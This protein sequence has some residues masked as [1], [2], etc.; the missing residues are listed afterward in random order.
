MKEL[1]LLA[2]EGFLLLTLVGV[3]VGELGYRGEKF[4][5]TW[6]TA[7]LGLLAALVQVV[8]LSRFGSS[9]AFSGSFRLD[10][11]A[12]ASKVFSIVLA[13]YVIGTAHFSREIAP[14]RR[15]EFLVFVLSGTIGLS[16][17]GSSNDLFLIYVSLQLMGISCA[18]IAG[19]GTGSVLS[20]EAAIKYQILGAVTGFFFLFG[21]AMAFGVT[22]TTRL[23]LIHEAFRS[24]AASSLV[25]TVTWIFLFIGLAFHL[26]VFPFHTWFADALDG[27]PAPASG[28]IAVS[29]RLG[30]ALAFVRI[31]TEV[32]GEAGPGKSVRW[33][34]LEAFDWTLPLAGFV[35]LTL[36]AGP[37]LA[38]GQ[39][40]A[41]RLVGA[42]AISEVGFLLLGV[43]VLD[44]NA[45]AAMFFSLFVSL[46]ALLGSFFVL[47]LLCDDVGHDELSRL[48]EGF[49]GRVFES[50]LLILFLCALIGTPPMPGFVA[51]FSLVGA[52]IDRGWY[53][54]AACGVIAIAVN[55][56]AVTRL[57]FSLMGHYASVSLSPAAGIVPSAGSRSERGVRAFLVALLFP[58][59]VAGVFSDPLFRLFRMAANSLFSR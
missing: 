52:A 46:F 57:F 56:L 53:A 31:S 24:G 27:A 51:K 35:A 28:F 15:T 10:G 55:S 29:S 45:L 36:L 33:Q 59:V 12:I 22:G 40:R 49:Q 17:L 4:R 37:F 11:V 8:L 13:I 2:P 44:R 54:L 3:I 5:T 58:L 7:T 14:R 26:A 6:M 21:T 39:S 1:I 47:Q 41:R 9:S 19:F 25:V 42:L 48:K 30:G 32:F 23:D 18:L 38:A 20:T 34:A 16:L 43:L 50:L